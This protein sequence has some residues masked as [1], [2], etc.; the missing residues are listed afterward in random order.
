MSPFTAHRVFL[1][2]TSILHLE[3]SNLYVGTSD[4][5]ISL[6]QFKLHKQKENVNFVVSCSHKIKQS[7]G[8]AFAA[9]C[10]LSC[11]TNVGKSSVLNLVIIESYDHIAALCGTLYSSH[12][13]QY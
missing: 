9:P 2:H 3:I 6:Y 7:G 12:I 10:Y 8:H 13:T 5:T 4:G 1:F 11:G